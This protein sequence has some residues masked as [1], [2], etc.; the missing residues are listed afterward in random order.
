MSPDT[1]CVIDACFHDW[2]TVK[3]RKSLQ[4]IFEIPLEKQGD[5]LALL[6]HPEPSGSKW[7]M[8]AL[9][10]PEKAQAPAVQA[11]DSERSSKPKRKFNELS[12]P[13]QAGI[14]CEDGRFERFLHDR[15]PDGF[16]TAEDAVRALCG[17]SSRRELSTNHA[18]A[19]KWRAIE[20]EFQQFLTDE[21]HGPSIINR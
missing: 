7:C 9:R 20:R 11:S 19:N 12:L 16:V 2:R 8:I 21:E 15:M 17:V 14:R 4:L 1:P 3:G 13:E 5:V 18:A 10:A 6:G